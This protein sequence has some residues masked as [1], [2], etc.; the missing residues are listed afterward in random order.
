MIEFVVESPLTPRPLDI[1]S[2]PGPG[3][4]CPELIAVTVELRVERPCD[5][6]FSR[7]NES[8]FVTI[9][10]LVDVREGKELTGARFSMTHNPPA[11]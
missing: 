9:A 7:V 4:D 8:L 5:E 3:N 11:L 6:D 1:D 2:V 10:V